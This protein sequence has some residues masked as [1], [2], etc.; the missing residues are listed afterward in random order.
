MLGTVWSCSHSYGRNAYSWAVLDTSLVVF[1]TVLV[2]VIVV[3]V[4]VVVNAVSTLVP[5]VLVVIHVNVF[6]FIELL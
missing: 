4:V 5:V 3:A 1:V 6:A 2:M